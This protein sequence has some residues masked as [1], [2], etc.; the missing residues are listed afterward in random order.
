M[1]K[2]FVI[3]ALLLGCA[4]ASVYEGIPNNLPVEIRVGKCVEKD[5]QTV[6]PILTH[7]HYEGYYE[8]QSVNVWALADEDIWVAF[9]AT[10]IEGDGCLRSILYP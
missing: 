1:I 5:L 6:Y 2:E 9:L 7:A 10:W 4:T 8:G 3:C